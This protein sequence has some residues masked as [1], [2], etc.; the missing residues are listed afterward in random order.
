MLATTV[1]F[2]KISLFGRDA[3][4]R[5]PREYNS[6]QSSRAFRTAQRAVPTMKL[7]RGSFLLDH[8]LNGSTN[9]PHANPYRARWTENGPLHSRGSEPATGRGDSKAFRSG[10][11]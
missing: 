6:E 5:R 3:A 2:G 1:R 7:L 10:V 9:L 11:V 8:C 4:L